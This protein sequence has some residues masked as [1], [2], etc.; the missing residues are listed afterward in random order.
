MIAIIYICKSR[1]FA[2]AK[3]MMIVF[4]YKRHYS[5]PIG[6]DQIYG[7]MVVKKNRGS[8]KQG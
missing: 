2:D 8:V 7:Y 3:S 4:V 5:M 1:G 6:I